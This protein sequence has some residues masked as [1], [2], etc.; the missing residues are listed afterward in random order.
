MKFTAD[1]RAQDHRFLTDAPRNPQCVMVVLCEQRPKFAM[2]YT[3]RYA[4]QVIDSERLIAMETTRD[5]RFIAL[6]PT[7]TY[8]QYNVV[9]D[10]IT[11]S[12]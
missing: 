7:C 11:N 8:W 10:R 4:T 2:N 6:S 12:I 3:T 1:I 5:S 9:Y